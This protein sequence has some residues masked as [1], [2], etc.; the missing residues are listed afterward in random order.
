M[1]SD[2]KNAVLPTLALLEARKIAVDKLRNKLM[3]CFSSVDPV[4][5][6]DAALVA[7]LS[8][9]AG[10]GFDQGVKFTLDFLENNPAW[11]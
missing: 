5:G 4:P 7:G 1:T 6:L 10:R 9:A 8:E 3:P 11:P 2:Q